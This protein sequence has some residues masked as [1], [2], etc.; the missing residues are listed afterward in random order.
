MASALMLV[1]SDR[2]PV[3]VPGPGPVPDRWVSVKLITEIYCR[4]Y[5]ASVAHCHAAPA[6]RA[7]C[8]PNIKLVACI[9]KIKKRRIIRC[10]H[11]PLLN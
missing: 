2:E 1:I 7:R 5:S 10:R 8:L 4:V 11:K 9:V 3:P 6:K